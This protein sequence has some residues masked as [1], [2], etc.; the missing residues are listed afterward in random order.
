MLEVRIKKKLK[1]FVLEAEF[2]TEGAMLGILGASG[3][4]KSMLQKCIAGIETP[5]EGRIILNGRTLYD[6]ER[7][8]NLKPQKRRV[9]YLFQDYALFPNMTV[10]QN[11]MSGIRVNGKGSRREIKRAGEQLAAELM[12][13]LQLSEHQNTYPEFLSG[14]QKQ[15]TALARILASEPEVLL[16][17]EP[18]S[19]LDV[20]LREELQLSF[21]DILKHSFSKDAV[22]VTHD[23][24]EAYR[25]CGRLLVLDDGR[26][27]GEGTRDEIFERPESIAAARITGC[28][29]I[30]EVELCPDGWLY[31]RAWGI[32]LKPE[33]AVRK[34][35]AAVGIHAR[36]FEVCAGEGINCIRVLNAEL[37]QSPFGKNIL[38]ETEQGGR[39]WWS[40][41]GADYDGKTLPEYLYIN[42]RKLLQLGR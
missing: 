16:L 10:K 26:I 11:I 31:A 40:C 38:F 29:N 17:D 2:C 7:K 36:D 9:G 4:G 20:Y 39:M 21:A 8:I 15:R 34:D 32:R 14:G 5:D 25:L 24:E 12:E 42:P 28:K 30:S 18:F 3:S 23:R 27:A 19:A 1:S 33:G 6:S 13:R 35:I 22:L 41:S 37:V